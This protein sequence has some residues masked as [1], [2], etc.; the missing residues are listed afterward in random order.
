MRIRPMRGAAALLLAGVAGVLP[1]AGSTP[2]MRA[3]WTLES[4][5]V[6]QRIAAP[7]AEDATAMAQDDQGYLWV[8]TQS[9]LLRWDGYRFRSYALDPATPG[10]LPD[11]FITALYIDVRSRLWVGT[12]AG[13]LARYEPEKDGFT[14]VPLRL[15]G[16]PDTNVSAITADG[17]GG[18]WVATGRGLVH[19]DGSTGRAEPLQD[20]ALHGA[21][22]RVE[23]LLRDRQGT[24]WAGTRHGLLRRPQGAVAFLSMPL[25]APGVASPVVSALLEDSA[26][27]VWIGT[28]EHGA[29]VVGTGKHTV[30]AVRDPDAGN[31]LATDSIASIAEAREG[32]IWLGTLAD[33]IVTID[34]QHGQARRERHDDAQG[35]TLTNDRI[36]CLYRDHAGLMWV[37]GTNAL[38]RYNPGQGAIG[39]YYGGSGR[40]RL[41]GDGSIP[42]VMAQP[43][44]RVWLGLDVGG[45]EIL[46]PAGGRVGQVPAVAQ[47]GEHA[48]PP[49]SVTAMARAPDAS[50][51]VGTT[52]G[53]FHVDASGRRVQPVDLQTRGGASDVWTLYLDGTHLWV[54]GIDGIWE[55]DLAV[56]GAPAVLRHLDS[57]LGDP[58]VT[59]L[60]PGTGSVL[61]IGTRSGVARLDRATG[62]VQRLPI[63]PLEQTALPGGAI[64]S[65]LIDRKGRLW[66]GTYGRGVQVQAGTDS[67]GRLRFRRLS[68]RDGL[69]QNSVDML[70][71]DAQGA[72]WVSTDDGLAHI[73]P[74]RLAIRAFR[75]EQGVGIR[76][77][78]A[79]SG[80]VGPSGEL[81]FGGING[82]AVIHPDRLLPVQGAPRLV[83]TEAHVGGKPVASQ[84]LLSNQPL[85][86]DARDRSLMV[87]FAALDFADPDH[88]RYSYRLQGF[89]T[90]WVSTPTSRRLASYT[91]L[92]AGD[93]TLQLRVAGPD[94]EW[95]A[96]LERAVHV[97]PAWYQRGIVRAAGALV[98]LLLLLGLVQLRTLYLRQRQRELQRLVAERTAELERRGVELRHSQEQ[99]EKM[100]YF[101]TLTGLPNRRMFNDEMRRL[102]ARTLRGQGGFALLL[103]DLDGF[104]QVNDVDGHDAGDA[105]LVAVAERLQT[106]VRENDRVARLGGDEFA[107]LLPDAGAD[108]GI[109]ATC[110]RMLARL[111]EPLALSGRVVQATA[112]IGVALCPQQGT[113]ADALYKSADLALYEAKRAGRNAWRWRLDEALRA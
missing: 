36:L 80:A 25:P 94:G 7:E 76:G 96:P 26:G 59:A 112:S 108:E 63:D 110:A 15:E 8:G 74:D 28:R 67:G 53:L 97:A 47:H 5:R 64:S 70:L 60:Q 86:I 17:T 68:T 32:E 12:N 4:D 75:A 38:S 21:Q 10:A 49:N 3:T 103:V 55:L 98:A 48:L 109:S 46:D 11:N 50:V 29:F 62:A 34:A 113:T 30:T 6:F 16:G 89:D 52:V 78:W 104:K 19:V 99:L 92:P 83:I 44:G 101:D 39:T 72:I 35:T 31:V 87:E 82:L 91:N 1:A 33:G 40:Y 57:E 95:M 77:F 23:S 111:A 81:L 79:G 90:D 56:A 51:F 58:R 2:A 24:L 66:V 100:A 42:S 85:P 20:P 18:L 106:L 69:P 22:A 27:R 107:V 93:Y 102:I 73:D 88:Q 61:W 37:G 41:L 45:I 43:D 54:G 13:G 71:A 84:V 65:L 105:L 14:V 9:G